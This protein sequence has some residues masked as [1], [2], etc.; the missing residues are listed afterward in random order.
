MLTSI[1]N[2]FRSPPKPRSPGLGAGMSDDDD[3][4]FPT[5]Q[6][7]WK[8]GATFEDMFGDKPFQ[9]HGSVGGS[10]ADNHRPDVAK[11]ETFLGDAGF[12]KPMTSEGPTGWHNSNLDQGIKAF[13]K[14]HG[15][16]V[17]GLLN[18]NGPTI[19]KIGGVLGGQTPP[20]PTKPQTDMPMPGDPDYRPLPNPPGTPR[21]P[22]GWPT[23]G[24]EL[25]FPMPTGG[26]I[27]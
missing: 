1:K 8:D 11:V 21:P 6:E 10:G 7:A 3:D 2:L 22:V 25:T 16:K 4:R 13:Q 27:G 20:Q 5:F 12:Y 14:A 18:P 19:T 15:L 26:G 23:G 17:D 24:P 9:L